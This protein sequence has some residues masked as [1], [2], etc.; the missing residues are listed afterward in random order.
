MQRAKRYE[1]PLTMLMLDIDYFKSINDTYGHAAGDVVLKAMA[2]S[3]SSIL[4]ASDIFGRLGGEEFAAILPQTDIEE[5]A[6]VAERLRSTLA[7]LGVEVG[8]ERVSFTVSVGVTRVDG[9]DRT[10]EEVLNRADEALYK[11]KRMGR[12]RVVRG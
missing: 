4:R 11:A 1:L 8:D 6:E 9:R 5:G 7:G 2:A 3:V 12:N 10:V